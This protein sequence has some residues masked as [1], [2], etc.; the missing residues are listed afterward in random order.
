MAGLK[1]GGL[2]P[3]QITFVRRSTAGDLSKLAPMASDLVERKVDLINAVSPVA[4]RA[5]MAA[6]KTIP[7]VAGDLESD[8]VAAGFVS[9][10][11][12]PGGNVTGVFLDF[13]DFSK[14]WLEAL[15]EAIPQLKNVALFWDP[16]T[17]KQQLSAVQSAAD[18]MGINLERIEVRSRADAEAG[19]AAASQHGASAVLMLSS[20]FIGSA[21]KM[22]ADLA[23]AQRLPAITLFTDFARNG[24]LMAYG[25]DFAAFT[26]EQGVMA[27]KILQGAKAADLPVET[28]TKFEFV[29]NL[30]TAKALNLPIPASLLLRADEVI[31]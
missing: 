31:E 12:R 23:T 22:L 26:R 15:T 21:P 17:G 19:F 11:A 14:K 30:K 29:L 18:T 16:G 1:A 5:A 7:I 13:P 9:S 6:T 3:D 27:S 25:P 4:I 24:G 8:P 2:Q 20:P 28:P 10:V